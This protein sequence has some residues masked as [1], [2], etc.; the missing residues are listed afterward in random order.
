MLPDGFPYIEKNYFHDF[1]VASDNTFTY[2]LPPTYNLTIGNQDVSITRH[3]YFHTG[4]EAL[5]LKINEAQPLTGISRYNITGTI[6][7]L[8][9]GPKLPW[10]PNGNVD[11]TGANSDSDGGAKHRCHHSN[12]WTAQSGRN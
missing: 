6:M 9:I 11:I 3:S 7:G 1:R 8:T 10:Y 12:L 2:Y 4:R 5:I